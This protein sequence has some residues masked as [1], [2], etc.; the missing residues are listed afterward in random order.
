MCGRGACRWLSAHGT[1]PQ[2]ADG[3]QTAVEF[4]APPD[5]APVGERV[6]LEGLEM[7]DPITP[8][9]VKK[10]KVWEEMVT[11]VRPVVPPA[12]LVRVRMQ[13]LAHTPTVRDSRALCW[14]FS[15]PCRRTRLRCSTANQ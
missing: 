7:V 8:A 6:G 13:V 11:K 1:L 15:S 10:Q 5:A 14:C 4:I 3:K 9:Q 2:D 12:A